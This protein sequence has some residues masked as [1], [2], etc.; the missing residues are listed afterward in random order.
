M[1]YIDIAFAIDENYIVQCATTMVSILKNTHTKYKLRFHI[2]CEKVNGKMNKLFD[3]QSIKDF[4]LYFYEVTLDKI[5]KFP[6]SMHW[7]SRTTYYRFLLPTVLP[8]EIE[9]CIYLDCDLIC[10]Q[11]IESLWSYDIDNYLA[12]AVNDI[13]ASM[14]N[15]RLGRPQESAYFNAGVLLLNLKNLREFDFLKMCEEYYESKK[16]C[17][18]A[19]DQDILNGVLCDSWL[20]L[21]L[22]YNI[23]TP[24]YQKITLYYQ[25]LDFSTR[26]EIIENPAIVHFTGIYK[27]WLSFVNHPFRDKYIEFES[28]TPYKIEYYFMLLKQLLRRVFRIEKYQNGKNCKTK[29]I[30]IFNFKIFSYYR[31]RFA[32]KIIFFSALKYRRLKN[33][34]RKMKK[35]SFV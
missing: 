8:I 19:Q 34:Y 13:A 15:K 4:E 12:G 26:T 10:M 24:L 17:I 29:D 22:I 3:L 11:D 20:Q 1:K 18:T 35:L 27:P 14:Y 7:I 23:C 31:C 16:E 33:R 30:Y 32:V 21:P 2:L 28:Y 5:S 25:E 9:K 6:L